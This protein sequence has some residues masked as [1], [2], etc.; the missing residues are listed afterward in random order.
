MKRQ[1]DA[2]NDHF[3]N[4]LTRLK[5]NVFN[6]VLLLIFERQMIY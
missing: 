2:E 3:R 5:V 4:E 6:P 1:K